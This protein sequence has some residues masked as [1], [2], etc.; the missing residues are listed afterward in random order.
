[1]KKFALMV[2]CSIVTFGSYALEYEKQFENDRVIVSRI[3]V[4][5]QEEIVMHYDLYPQVVFVLQGGTITRL[6][7]DGSTND[8]VFP[9]G[10]TIFIPAETPDK[11]HRAINNGEEAVE[12]VVTQLK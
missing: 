12:I 2:A 4:M 5:A 10:K 3:K 11:E 6:E 7:K 1:V 9:M 8:V